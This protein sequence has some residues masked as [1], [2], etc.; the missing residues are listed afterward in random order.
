MLTGPVSESCCTCQVCA[1]DVNG[2]DAPE[3]LLS[4][5]IAGRQTKEA[6]NTTMLGGILEAHI[7][8]FHNWAA[9]PKWSTAPAGGHL[10]ILPFV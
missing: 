4:R 3:I 5:A 8:P 1:L 9:H 6:S 10:N 2:G 7:W